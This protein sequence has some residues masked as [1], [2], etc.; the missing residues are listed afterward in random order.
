MRERQEWRDLPWA[1]MLMKA[2][3]AAPR[4]PVVAILIGKLAAA[5]S[6]AAHP[7]VELA[8]HAWFRYRYISRAW[9]HPSL[10]RAFNP[11]LSGISPTRERSADPFSQ[12]LVLVYRCLGYWLSTIGSVQ[13]QSEAH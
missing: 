3:N 8:L 13:E 2:R 4:L 11:L 12:I 9:N 5:L 7:G 1:R 6:P 10:A